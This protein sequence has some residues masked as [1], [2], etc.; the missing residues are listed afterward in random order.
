MVDLA[1]MT[2]NPTGAYGHEPTLL[3]E[4]RRGGSKG[5]GMR[6]GGSIVRPASPYMDLSMLIG[7]DVG[8]SYW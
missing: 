4:T 5:I 8:L 2:E 6:G 3:M 1:L 7:T